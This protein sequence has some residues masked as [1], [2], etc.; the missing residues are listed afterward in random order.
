MD[1][2]QSS[3][4]QKDLDGLHFHDESKVDKK[5]QV[6]DPLWNQSSN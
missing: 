4:Y 1:I 6:L 3:T 5:Q 2:Y